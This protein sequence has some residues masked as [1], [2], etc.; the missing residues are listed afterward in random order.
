[1]GIVGTWILTFFLGWIGFTMIL[2][3]SRIVRI[4]MG[5]ILDQFLILP[6]VL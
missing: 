1:M 5:F 6:F 3:G 2:I 4:G